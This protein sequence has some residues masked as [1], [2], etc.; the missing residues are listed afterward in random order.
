MNRVEIAVSGM[1]RPAWSAEL[2]AFMSRVLNAVGVDGWEVS[3]LLCDTRT[4]RGLNARYRGKNSPTD[5]LSFRQADEDTPG[6]AAAAGDVVI[7]LEALAKNAEAEGIS[8]GEEIARLAVHGILH[9]IGMDHGRGRSGKMLALQEKLLRELDGN[10][11]FPARLRVSQKGDGGGRSLRG[12]KGMIVGLC[13]AV[14]AASRAYC[15]QGAAALFQEGS[16]AQATENYYQAIEQYKASLDA[17]SSYL[18]PMRGLAECFFSLEEYDEALRWVEQAKKYGRGDPDLLVLEGRILIGQGDVKTARARFTEVLS[19]QPNNL[20]ARFGMAEAEVAEGRTREALSRYVK[21]LGLAPESRKALLALALLC[22]E[23]GDATGAAKYFELVLR[24]HADDPHVEL[25]AGAWYARNGD[26]DSAEKRAKIALSLKPGFDAARLLLGSVYLQRGRNQDAIDAFRQIITANRDNAL[27]WYGL[28]QAYATVPDAEKALSSFASALSARPEDEIARIAQEYAALDWLKMDDAQRKKMGAFHLD[29]GRLLENS[30]FQEKALSEYRRA[31]LVDPISRD[32]RVAYARIFR[33]M[34]FPARYRNEL[35]VLTTLGVKDVFVSDE[36][37][38][39]TS[40]LADSLSNAWGIDQFAVDRAKYKIPVFTLASVNRLIH[41]QASGILARYF[42][43]SLLR[44]ES[45]QVPSLP[46]TTESFE[47][48]FKAAREKETDFFV[49]L[50]VDESERSFS[51]TADLYLSRTGARIASF[52][53][54]RTGNDRIRDCFLKI[55]AALTSTLTPRG[56][57]LSRKLDIG[58]IDL[59]SFQG[60]KKDDTLVVVRR[61]MVRLDPRQ[62]GLAYE[63][64]DVLGSFTV[65]ATDEG[66]AEGLLA[67]KGYFDF[68][69]AGDEIVPLRREEK[70]LPPVQAAKST[71]NILTR[72]FGIK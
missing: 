1:K 59:G 52:S 6:N 21:A 69:N 33:A 15:A 16:R 61:G 29:S 30:N 35:L 34:G 39:L 57:L 5:V 54:F 13:L 40:V 46:A 12:K 28:G 72:L 19:R 11:V 56:T 36:I 62:P 48:A 38:A 58:V 49:L 3:V 63:D 43:D 4:I 14:L 53:A 45:V 18:A 50:G 42:A 60:M 70:P 7:C 26:Y 41:P 67:R 51:A 65:S 71:G 66:I 20:E 31:L 55:A 24:M 23:T 8:E 22:E 47:S 17:N 2:K 64:A 10:D 68:I 25:E 32:A 27:A 37:D 44:S 9:L